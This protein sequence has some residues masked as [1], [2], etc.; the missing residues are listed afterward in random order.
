MEKEILEYQNQKIRIGSIVSSLRDDKEYKVMT[1]D[2]EVGKPTVRPTDPTYR[3]WNIN[4]T[5][6]F[7]VIE[8]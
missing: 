1:L 4:L 3:G 7:K 6:D 2:S 5:F 8:F